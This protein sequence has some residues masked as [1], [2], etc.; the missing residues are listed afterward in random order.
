MAWIAAGAAIGGALISNMG[1]DDRNSAQIGQADKQMDF[2]ERMSNTAYQRATKDMMDA[3]LNPMLAYSQ[4][5][6]STPAGAQANIEDAFTPAVSS[7]KDIYRDVSQAK[8]AQTQVANVEADTGVK[9]T[10]ASLNV[11]MADKV[12]QE[13]AT[14]AAQAA[15]LNTNEQ[16]I[17]MNMDKIEPEIKRIL[18]DANLSK[19]QS[20]R[21]MSEI[22]LI[23][24]QIPK[25]QAETQESYSR[26]ILNE[27]RSRLYSLDVNKSQAESDMWGSPYGRT[28]PYTTTGAKTV[29]DAVDIIKPFK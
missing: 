21:V 12:R 22:P 13:T 19:M 17:R 25:T 8:V 24:A 18:A 2:Q 14:S 7:A 3:G 4:G 20:E 10:Q 1:A 27:V 11:D 6:A 16:S 28:I 9:N 15:F 26:R 5:G 23:M 29:K